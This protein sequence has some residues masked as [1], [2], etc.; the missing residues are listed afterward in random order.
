MYD[1]VV[2]HGSYGSPFENW[3]PW[4]TKELE[5]RGANVLVPQF[6]CG[7]GIQ[8][9]KNWENV[10]DAYAPFLG[11]ETIFI[12]HSLAPAFI[13]DYLINKEIKIKGL[14]CV[15][16]FYHPLGLPEFDEVNVPFFLKKDL[17]RIRQLAEKRTC[18]ISENDPYVPK[19]LSLDFAEK[20]KATTQFIP[21]AGHFNTTAGYNT[22]DIL[23]QEILK[24]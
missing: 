10:L 6:P 14:Y 4:L 19:D 17:L 7:K 24:G 16:P 21:N 3:F 9:Y 5:T 12:G 8:N 18:F 20:I 11:P 1:F 23:L 15:A 2:I 22:F 13:V